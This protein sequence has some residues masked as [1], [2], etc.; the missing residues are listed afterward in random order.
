MPFNLASRG[1]VS[2]KHRLDG[3]NRRGDPVASVFCQYPDVSL[4]MVSRKR[5]LS[6]LLSRFAINP[7]LTTVHRRLS[8][9]GT[10]F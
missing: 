3:R 9:K 5:V 4:W 7:I 6:L 8:S 2:A 10:V 1:V